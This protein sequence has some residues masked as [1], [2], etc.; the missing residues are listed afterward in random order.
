M[1][2]TAAL[3]FDLADRPA[4]RAQSCSA[5]AL[6]TISE[7][8]SVVR[9]GRLAVG[10][11][12]SNI[13]FRL[14]DVYVFRLTRTAAVR[15]GMQQTGQAFGD[16]E[17][18]LLNSDGSQIARDD[19]G[20]PGYSS[21]IGSRLDA[22]TY[23]VEA[24]TNRPGGTFTYSLSIA[25]AYTHIPDGGAGD[26]SGG[27]GGDSGTPTTVQPS[28]TDPGALQGRIVARIVNWDAGSRDV[29]CDYQI[30]FGLLPE[31]A[32]PP[33]QDP[34]PAIINANAVL[35][36]A[37]YLTC[38]QILA[39]EQRGNQRW[40]PSSI[41]ELPTAAPSSNG[42]FLG[43]GDDS[44][45]TG[46]VIVRYV[47]WRGASLRIEFGFLPGWAYTGNIGT[48]ETAV[49]HAVLPSQ[50]YINRTTI[51]GGSTVWLFSPAIDI[52]T[53]RG[54]GTEISVSASTVTVRKGEN[55]G[56]R[57]VGQVV[58][59]VAAG[60]FGVVLAPRLPA[61]L[62]IELGE[63]VRDSRGQETRTLV[64]TGSVA[65]TTAERTY[66]VTI[67]VRTPSGQNITG[68]LAIDVEEGP[69]LPTVDWD[70]YAKSVIVMGEHA[71][72]VTP[73][74][75]EGPRNPVWNYRSA[76][77][78]ICE[79]N[80]ASGRV[81]GTTVG[82]CEIVVALA[83]K[84]G[85]GEKTVIAQVRI[86]DG[87][88]VDINWEGYEPSRMTVGGD[89]PLLL[90]PS[91]TDSRTRR[92]VSL[93]YT[94]E[95][96]DASADVCTVSR[97]SAQITA[98]AEGVCRV[99]AVSA[100]T[101]TYASASSDW[102][103]V[104][105]G[106]KEPSCVSLDYPEQTITVGASILPRPQADR[107]CIGLLNYETT[108]PEIC[109]ISPST[110]RLTARSEGTCRATVTSA[111]TGSLL[112]G[113]D[114]AAVR[115]GPKESR[116]VCTL[117]YPA[118]VE[119]GARVS[120]ALRCSPGTPA[121]ASTTSSICSVNP[122]S[123]DVTGV[124]RGSCVIRV[125]VGETERYRE[126]TERATI[127][128]IPGNSSPA[129][130]AIS[131]IT[132]ESGG[133]SS[134]IDLD[135]YCD[136]PDDDAL[137]YHASP[138]ESDSSWATATGSISG[139]QLVINGVSNRTGTQTIM[140]A[141]ADPGG[142]HAEISIR[143]TVTR[144]LGRAPECDD[145]P[146]TVSISTENPIRDFQPTDYCTDPDGDNLRFAATSSD[147]NVAIADYY[148][149]SRRWVFDAGEPGTA[150]IT[151][152]AT[153]PSG[154]SD[155]TEITVR[156]G[157]TTAV[158]D[159]IPNDITTTINADRREID[160]SRYF[161]HPSGGSLTYRA[162]S[163]STR[164]AR[165]SVSGNTLTISPGSATGVANI[166]VSVGGSGLQTRNFNNLFE[167]IVN[168]GSTGG[169]STSGGTGGGTQPPPIPPKGYGLARCG[170]DTIKV[171]YFEY[172]ARDSSQW[173]K[174]HLDVTWESAVSIWARSG[175]TW[176]ENLIDSLSQSQCDQWTTG[177]RYAAST[178]FTPRRP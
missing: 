15:I 144:P 139:S 34:A 147:S 79:V 7:S 84:D 28:E 113:E 176:G 126:Q 166:S 137:T 120:A 18:F 136:D 160:L 29:D 22:G 80:R 33:G 131:G 21:L 76:T 2:V 77:S 148:S 133:S 45:V 154:L 35:P 96:D 99:R 171:Y 128:V 55:I 40:L 61:D 105:V 62:G 114:R 121:F 38:A 98:S 155:S 165:V 125:T 172:T 97:S 175:L 13:S 16:P 82:E 138:W 8:G 107:G 101:N 54:G 164:V 23:R 68:Q 50:R 106:G 5:V 19:D 123:G 124:A 153:D 30:E 63:A 116:S 26:D 42:G 111:A 177:S 20:G 36:T 170:T 102:V 173:S 132:V 9:E 65:R 142:L 37:R 145:D 6:G 87:P 85:W 161:R 17:L 32:V 70:G 3:A 118:S 10:D 174:H 47:L 108:T 91:A 83:P 159:G 119:I 158:Q 81:T 12:A 162:S 93:R 178:S 56:T 95:R 86:V 157:S 57:R 88:I 4:A 58:G 115:I 122:N 53:E 163:D 43:G 134:P 51:A 71:D 64:L 41:I 24:A 94:F 11:C 66:D 52:P 44:T 74:I 60:E 112:E 146:A 14:A 129:C 156:V 151:L 78:E 46:Y 143:V 31:A 104:A 152:R 49:R 73:V 67:S 149:R 141:A 27:N 140:I 75:I 1:A 72:P 150:T 92:S 89:S 90:R 109:S 127:R 130:R 168:Q 169:G 135:D 110:G 25:V 167:V 48:L 39:R 103:R 100:R 117:D 59:P 69:D